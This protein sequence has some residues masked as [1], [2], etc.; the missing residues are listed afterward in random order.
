MRIQT[1]RNIAKSLLAIYI[2]LTVSF[3][4]TDSAHPEEDPCG[5]ERRA[6]ERREEQ[7][8]DAEENLEEVQNR[9]YLRTMVSESHDGMITGAVGGAAGGAIGG[10]AA[11]GPA[12]AVIGVAGGAAGGGIIGGVTGLVS[13]A[14]THRDDLSDAEDELEKAERRHRRA[15]EELEACEIRNS[16]YT[17]TCDD[18]GNSWGFDDYDDYMNFPSRHDHQ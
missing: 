14:M 2:L 12:G 5:K 9:G 10:G 8:S 18:C 16:E 15:E 1:F 7:V 17:Y 3:V 13:G 6:V 4:F 11:A